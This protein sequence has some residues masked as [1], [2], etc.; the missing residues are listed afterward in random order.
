MSEQPILSRE[1]ILAMCLHRKPKVEAVQLPSGGTVYVRS[2]SGVEL[3]KFQAGNFDAK[4][5]YDP[6]TQGQRLAALTLC[7]AAG[8]RLFQDGQADTLGLMEGAD[9]EAI[10]RAARRISKQDAA[11]QEQ[12]VKNSQTPEANSASGTGSPPTSA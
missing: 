11:S 5:D 9:L 7:D 8:A 1:A 4:G 2:M 6:A 10:A 12:A 3:G